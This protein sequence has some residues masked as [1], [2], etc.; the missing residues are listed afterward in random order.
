MVSCFGV[1]FTAVG[2]QEAGLGWMQASPWVLVVQWPQCNDGSFV[3]TRGI[4]RIKR[5]KEK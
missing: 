5:R 4:K 2:G 1:F 3:S